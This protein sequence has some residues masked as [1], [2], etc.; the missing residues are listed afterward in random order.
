MRKAVLVVTLVLAGCAVEPQPAPLAFLPAPAPAPR[1]D[2]LYTPERVTPDRLEY[3]PD[4]DTF[5]PILTERTAYPTQAQA[6][7]AFA[8]A[9]M[10]RGI[11]IIKASNTVPDRRAVTSGEPEQPVSLR[12]FACKP[13]ALDDQTGRL[14]R[15]PGP[16]VH[17][18]T[19]FLTA[20]QESAF[21]AT[22]NFYYAKHA[23]SMRI[24][25][26]PTTRVAWLTVDH[27]PTDFWWWV[28][29][30]DRYQ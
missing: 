18:A 8:R 27:S 24:T 7:N 28:P 23:W 29:G 26:P 19:D 5:A 3:S 9:T 25:Q 30:R 13:G 16:V 12:L 11:T 17:C 21:R 15:Y 10:A 14:E 22:V 6:N 4:R 20:A 1:H 2:A